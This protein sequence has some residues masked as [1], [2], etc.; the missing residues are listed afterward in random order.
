MQKYIRRKLQQSEII[1][2]TFGVPYSSRKLEEVT[3]V[4][5]Y[6]GR[7]L[8]KSPSGVPYTSGNIYKKATDVV[9]ISRKFIYVPVSL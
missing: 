2:N 6:N 3:L 4:R 5:A 8:V 9:Y 7:N 1:E